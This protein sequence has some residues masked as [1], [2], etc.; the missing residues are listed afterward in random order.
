MIYIG[1]VVIVFCLRFVYCVVLYLHVFRRHDIT[2]V[3]VKQQSI[4]THI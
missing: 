3:G 4:T 1:I 2:E